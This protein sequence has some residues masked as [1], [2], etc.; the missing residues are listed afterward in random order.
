MWND[1]LISEEQNFLCCDDF[2]LRKLML[3]PYREKHLYRRNPV[4]KGLMVNCACFRESER[5]LLTQHEHLACNLLP[6]PHSG[7][8][9][10]IAEKFTTWNGFHIGNRNVF[11]KAFVLQHSVKHMSA[12]LKFGSCCQVKN[13][14]TVDVNNVYK[15]LEIMWNWKTGIYWI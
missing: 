4:V 2:S 7:K 15:L 6:F 10:T 12:L 1:I 14:L 13:M 9:S 11:W 3:N 8:Q 5:L